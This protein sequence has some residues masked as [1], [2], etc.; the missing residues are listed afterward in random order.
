M[1]R[2]FITV[3]A[4]LAATLVADPLVILVSID[5]CRWDYPEL[6]EAPTLQRIATEGFRVERL[7]PSYP[8]K[9]FP[10]H[11]T[12]VTGLHP[13]SH[14]IIQN[15]FWDDNFEAWFGIG[16]HPAAREGR[17]WGGEPIW[18]TA[19]RQGLRTAC[20]FWPG[21]EADIK[22]QYPDKWR[23]YDGSISE[24][25]RVRQVLQWTELPAAER[26]HF[27]TLYFEAVDSAGHSFGP[28]AKQTGSAL[29]VVDQALDQLRQRLIKQGLWESTHLIITSDHG[30]TDIDTSRAI[31]LED[32][33]NLDDVR[34]IFDGASGGLNAINP[35]QT[36]ELV[37]ALN[38]HPH[39]KAFTRS[40]VPA[41][42][43]FSAND[44]IPDIVLIPDL[45]WKTRKRPVSPGSSNWGG[46]HGFDN[47]EPD[48]ASIFI[49]RGP[50]FDA[51]KQLKS[52]PNTSVYNLLCHLLQITPAPNEGSQILIPNSE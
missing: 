44:R 4:L 8:T 49:G 1:L 36:A 35:S 42:L 39:L 37:Q 18:L 22:G 31:V 3:W 43:H 45:G 2:R 19:Q 12:L 11:Y 38:Q 17:W 6:H 40:D 32:L 27:I 9:T 14:G 21:T 30:M 51:G 13:E 33:I 34:I 50:Q 46:D 5:G 41:R 47:I 15:K 29:Q 26:P 24:L 20:M 52:A 28:T 16:N 10:N 48:M 23:R 7:I 25:D